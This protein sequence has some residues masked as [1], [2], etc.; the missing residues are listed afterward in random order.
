MSTQPSGSCTK[1]QPASGFQDGSSSGLRV[2]GRKSIQPPGSRT[3]IRPASGFL[4]ESPSSLRVPGRKSIQ[5][6]I[7]EESHPRAM[8]FRRMSKSSDSRKTCPGFSGFQ[9]STTQGHPSIDCSLPS[10]ADCNIT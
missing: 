10:G 5:P 9:E 2:L 4:D 7:Y 6:P 8:S 3:K 1:F